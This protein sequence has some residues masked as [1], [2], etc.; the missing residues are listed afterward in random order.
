MKKVWLVR[1]HTF[2]DPIAFESEEDAREY[3]DMISSK[4][5]V[6]QPACCLFVPKTEKLRG[7]AELERKQ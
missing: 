7:Y 3:I 1:Q 6:E 2:I 4:D 5:D